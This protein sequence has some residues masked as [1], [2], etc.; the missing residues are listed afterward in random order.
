MNFLLHHAFAKSE[1]GC[2]LA[3]VGAMLPDFWRM[4]HPRVRARPSEEEAGANDVERALSRGV[5]HHLAI[6][7]WFHATEV[8]VN[9]ERETAI[10]LRR[11]DVPKI[12][13]F[14]HVCWEMCLDGAWVA[15]AGHRIVDPLREASREV[16]DAAHRLAD[17]HGALRLSTDDRVRFA[18]RVSWMIAG[19]ADGEWIAGYADPRGLCERLEAMRVRRFRLPPMSSSQIT[20]VTS[21]LDARL[22]TA[23]VALDQLIA[24]FD[25]RTDWRWS[26][27]PTPCARGD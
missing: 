24:A 14:A 9:G 3:A 6:D 13:L 16:G 2:S 27:E 20:M 23:S 8:F 17:R 26:L 10:Q 15:R 19:V 11:A 1:L 5:A 12:G 22:K 7:R 21:T 25:A 4:A 18:E